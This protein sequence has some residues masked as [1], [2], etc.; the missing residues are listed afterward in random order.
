MYRNLKTTSAVSPHGLTVHQVS[1]RSDENC[2]RSYPEMKCRQI[3]TDTKWY[4]IMPSHYLVVAYKNEASEGFVFIVSDNQS[5]QM[6]TLTIWPQNYN[7]GTV[8]PHYNDSICSQ[9]CKMN[10]LLCRILNEQ[11]DMYKRSCF[12]LTFF[13]NIC[14]G[15]FFR[16]ASL[17][18]F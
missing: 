18:Q 8:N 14:F 15:Y 11:I 13:W 6:Q 2:R 3:V 12:V 17:R 5:I 16:I 9:S 7:N 1:T 4:T 10:L